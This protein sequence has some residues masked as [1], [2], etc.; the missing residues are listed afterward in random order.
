MAF[1]QGLSGLN[2]SSR[3]IDVVSNNVANASTVGF[4]TGSAQFSDVFASA[5]SGATTGV[6]VGIGSSVNAVRQAFTQGNLAVSSNPLDMAINGNGF[7]RMQRPDGSVAYTRNGQFDVDRDGFIISANNDRLTGFR[8]S[9]VVNG[10][11]IFEGTPSVLQIDSTNIPPQPTRGE[12]GVEITANLDSRDVNPTTRTPPSPAFDPS[13][14]PIPVASYNATTSLTV[15]DS[16][17]NPHSLT[18]YFVRTTDP[19]QRSWSVWAG[20]NGEAPTSLTGDA[21]IDP[22]DPSQGFAPANPLVFNA[23]GL[24][25]PGSPTTFDFTRTGADLNNG[26]AD[27]TFGVNLSRVTQ[28]G[29]AF[30]VNRLSQNGYTTGQLTGL[31]VSRDGV[32]QGRYSNGQTQDI[33]KVALANFQSPNGLIALGNNLWAESPDSG[34]PVVGSP[35]TGVLG[36]LSAGTIEESNVD[37]T[38][39]L[40][41]LIIQQRNYQANAQSIRAQDQILQT[42]VNLR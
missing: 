8:V 4:K 14:D 32:I 39:E 27:L 41:Q 19:T 24:I 35:G 12:G 17:G 26:A 20:L 15:F 28:F 16:L 9:S 30:S 5:L 11:S 10:V 6:Q 23:E 3:A 18:L 13:A 31:T 29:D 25:S 40:V 34:Q 42:L 33:G 7:F 21:P 37:L 2:S 22:A 36:V 38:Q 1:Q